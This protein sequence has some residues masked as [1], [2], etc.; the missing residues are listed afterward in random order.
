MILRR[1]TDA[2]R[3]Q[4]WFT[5]LIETLIVVLGVF[6]GIQLG[7]WNEARAAKAR[8]T[9]LLIELKEE[10]ETSIRVTN[11]KAGA[12]EQVVSAGKR[13]LDF[14]A[15]GDSCGD[16]CWPVLVD[17]FHASQ[18]QTIDVNHTTYDE[19]RRQ[20]LPRSRD[21]IAAVEAYL[22]QNATL[23]V[24]NFVP[25]YRSRVRQLIPLEAQSYYWDACFELDNGAES[26]VLDCPK[27]VSDEVAAKTVG[28][29]LADPDIEPLL[30]E[31]AG[32]MTATPSDL[33]DQNLAAAH[34]V[35]VIN[36]ELARR[37]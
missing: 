15:S 33:A 19:M 18:W 14:M 26:Y 9:A 1:L 35:A 4:D 7:N 25:V 11:Q 32:L 2:F 30:T 16:E 29:I 36:E 23:S 8:E 34:A 31:W 6:L 20:G 24:T 22:A 37:R 21:V 28:K 5:V 17:F 10:I 12:I 13:S 27:G 3:K